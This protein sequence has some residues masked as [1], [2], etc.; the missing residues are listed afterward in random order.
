MK[1][2][3][4][5]CVIVLILTVLCNTATLVV[6]SKMDKFEKRIDY[7]EE[8][9]DTNPEESYKTAQKCEE[10]FHKE[11]SVLALFVNHEKL[12]EL[13]KR[14]AKIRAYSKQKDFSY[15]LSE[16]A[17]TEMI[18]ED[19]TEDQKFLFHTVF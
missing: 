6:N 19:I 10:D 1:R 17:E 11:E 18:I 8:L 12:D 13:K 5:A 2:F 3:Y 7:I 9:D 16:C 15:L 14:L 4:T